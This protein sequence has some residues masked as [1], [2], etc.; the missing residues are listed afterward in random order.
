MSVDLGTLTLR[1]VHP[2]SPVLL[3]KKSPLGALAFCPLVQ[4][5]IQAVLTNLKFDNRSRNF[6]PRIL[7][8]FALPDKTAYI[9]APAI[10]RETSE[11]T[12]Y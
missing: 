3:T 11:G 5:S 9:F 2:A 6:V 8:S 1:S 4:L 7:Y 12:S 10:L